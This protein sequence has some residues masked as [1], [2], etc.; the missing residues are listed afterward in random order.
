MLVLARKI[1]PRIDDDGRKGIR[2]LVAQGFEKRIAGGIRQGKVK[3]HAV[4]GLV[5]EKNKALGGRGSG[6]GFNFVRAQ[7]PPN[8]VTLN[9][10]VLDDKNPAHPLSQLRL[11]LLQNVSQVLSLHGLQQIADRAKRESCLRIVG[12]RNHVD[13]DMAGASV[14]L[15]LVEHPEAR[16]IR[17]ADVQHDGVRMEFLRKRERLGRASG[18]KAFELHLVGKIPKDSRETLIVFDNEEHA[19]LASEP[20]TIVLDLAVRLAV[21]RGR[22]DRLRRLK[23][24]YRSGSLSRLLPRPHSRCAIGLGN[25]DGERGALALRASERERSAE[26]AD[27]FPTD[28]QPEAGATILAADRS[29]C[30]PKGLKNGLLFVLRNANACVRDA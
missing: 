30:L 10:V 11:Q 5:L 22:R 24:K 16:M 4:K 15:E 13:R 25:E 6:D 29:V 26:Q 19:P 18:H 20:F 9:R 21:V 23:L 8:C 27:K 12:R 3:D 2:A 7:E 28:R 1:A 17:Q 14:A